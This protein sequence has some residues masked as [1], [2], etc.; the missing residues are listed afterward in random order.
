MR[1]VRGYDVDWDGDG[2][3]A[4]AGTVD[5]G[6]DM[7]RLDTEANAWLLLIVSDPTSSY[8]SLLMS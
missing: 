2:P 3:G 5:G 6:V 1:H 4:A 8:V 7:D